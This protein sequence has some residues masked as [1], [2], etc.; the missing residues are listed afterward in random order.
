LVVTR[1][2]GVSAIARAVRWR[3]LVCLLVALPLALG[4][5]AY[6]VLAPPQYDAKTTVAFSPRLTSSVGADI[7]G[8]VLPRYVALLQAGA[9]VRTVSSVASVPEDVI[10]SA[11][12]S[13]ATDSANLVIIVRASDPDRAARA[14]NALANVALRASD[15]DELL[16]SEQVGRA[17]PPDAPAAP[18]RN[19]LLVAGIVAGLIAGVVAAVVTE[20]L[21]PRV[22]K[23]GGVHAAG[24]FDVLGHVPKSRGLASGL[25]TAA[26]DPIV[27]SAV[28]PVVARAEQAARPD[29]APVLGITSPGEG[30]GRTTIALAYAATA[31][32]QGR[33]VV[34][35]HVDAVPRRASAPDTTTLDT[36]SCDA[37]AAPMTALDA[38]ALESLLVDGPVEGVR[39]L[40]AEQLPGDLD[41]VA[42]RLPDLV[43]ELQQHADLVL[44]DCPPVTR[45]D[46]EAV[47]V[48]L[49][50][51]LVVVRSGTPI[52]AVVNTERILAGVGARVLGV[53]IDS[54]TRR[55]GR[56]RRPPAP[57]PRDADRSPAPV[58]APVE[59]SSQVA[60]LEESKA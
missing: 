21:R 6:A 19:L 24:P 9:T 5:G 38:P 44:V 45:D 27:E 41:L 11:K 12:V 10:E 15:D 39:M 26:T 46:G 56:R 16:Q 43:A 34:V 47:L 25:T 29:G 23:R 37:Q 42:H 20:R 14:A 60:V 2:Q 33:R 4:V 59:E 54:R 36:A 30:H 49:P 50:A 8:V 28:R 53:V 55:S 1:E 3:W 17:L 13:I 22:R 57:A 40:H 32:R 52:A 31:A 18:P 35:L 51:V 58:T 48:Q 7:I